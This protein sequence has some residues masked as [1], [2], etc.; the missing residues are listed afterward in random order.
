MLVI[1]CTDTLCPGKATLAQSSQWHFSI[2]ES[3]PT[4]FYTYSL[5]PFLHR[6][7]TNIF[8]Q[9]LKIGILKFRIINIINN[10]YVLDSCF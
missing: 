6:V 9:F 8:N 5:V 2:D 7:A 1:L 3:N 4:V 10:F